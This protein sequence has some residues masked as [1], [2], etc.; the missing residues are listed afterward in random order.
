MLKFSAAGL[1]LVAIVAGPLSAKDS[2]G[3]FSKWAAFRDASVPRCYAISEAEESQRQSDFESYA[4]IGTWPA[5]RIRSQVHFRLS[6]PLQQNS[7]VSLRVGRANFVLISGKADAWASDTAM[8]RAIV[9][10]MRNAQ[11]MTVS[12]TDAR[13]RRFS[14]R[15]QLVGA[16]SAIDAATLACM[17]R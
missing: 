8:D 2:L 17:R 3:V 7:R 6:R 5:R 4:T 12:A 1:A 14:D 10:A 13:G 9:T 11:T 16:A 15:Y